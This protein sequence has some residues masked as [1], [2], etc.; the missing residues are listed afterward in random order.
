MNSSG[1][2]LKGQNALVTGANSGIGEAMPTT[3]EP[4]IGQVHPIL[5]L[6]ADM[7][8]RHGRRRMQRLISSSFA[9]KTLAEQR[10]RW[11]CLS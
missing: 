9:H 4:R 3:S 6:G 8:E 10:R 11:L 7:S 2:L 1:E 5:P